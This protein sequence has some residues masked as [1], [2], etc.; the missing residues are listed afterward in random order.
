MTVFS[1]LGIGKAERPY[2][3]LDRVAEGFQPFALA[4]LVEEAVDRSNSILFIARN[5]QKIST[6]KQAL[7]FINPNLSVLHFPAWDC[8]P[9]DR[10]SPGKNVSSR[11]LATLIRLQNL[12]KNPHPTVI[13]T[14]VNAVIQKLLPRKVLEKEI[15]SAQVGQKFDMRCLIN[16][17]EYNGFWRVSIV[18][19]V[20]EYAVRGG[21]VDLFMPGQN[22]PV[23]LDFFNDT[24]EAVRE[25]DPLTQQTR[26][27]Q[28]GFTFQP[29]SEIILAP[30]VIYRFCSNYVQAFGKIQ[31][32]DALYQ[33]V[34]AGR[35]F[36][37]MEHWLPLFYDEVET[38]F[39]HTGSMPVIFD[40]LAEEAL[41]ERYRLIAHYYEI[42]REYKNIRDLKDNAPYHPLPMD[43]FYLSPQAFFS[44]QQQ[45][46]MRIDFTPSAFSD[47]NNSIRVIS[48]N[49]QEFR[50]FSLERDNPNI[51]LLAA[52][53]DY[54][55]TLQSKGRKVLLAGW[56]EGSLNRLIQ[57]FNEQ[58]LKK[59]EQVNTLS[60]VRAAPR[61]LICAGIISIEHGF[62]TN[63]LSVISEKD[64][65]GD[66]FVQ[67][68]RQREHKSDFINET[69][70]LNTGDI[71]VHID[72]GIGRFFCLKTIIASGAPHDCLE[73]HYAEEDR[74]FLPVENIDLLSRYGGGGIDTV[75]D[76]LGSGAW[77]IR[78]AKLKKRLLEMA[79]ELINIAAQRQMLS[80]PKLIPSIDLYDEFSARF[81]YHETEDQK[82]AI[83]AVL[84]DLS[85]GT[86]MDRLI[87]G[88]VGFGKTEVAIRA[89]FSVA[90]SGLQVAVVVPTT[91]LARQHYEIFTA[92][93]QGLPVR[94]SHA[95][96]FVG[97]RE[98]ADI[99]KEIRN[100]TVDIIIGTHTLLSSNVQFANLGL[101]IID[102]EQHFGVKHKERLK[103]LKAEIHVLTLSATPIPRTLQLALTGVRELSL[104]A[105]PPI[106]RIAVK[107]SILPVDPLII[108]E[109][110]LREHCRGG[111]SFYICPR[112]ADIEEVKI[113]LEKHT[114]ELKVTI[115]H[116][117]LAAS[118]L[119]DTMTAFY[120]GQYDILLSTSI[121]ESGLDIPTANTLI[122]HRSD[123]FGLSALYQ[124]RG[125]IGR[126][127]QQAYALFT[128]PPAKILT[129]KAERRFNVL[130]SLN[131]LGAGF[132]LATHDMDIRGAGNLLGEEQ[133]G[134]IKEVG[135]KLYQQ[136]LE[137]AV[138]EMKGTGE[139]NNLHWSPQISIGTS[140]MIP[141][142]YIPD[143]Q[144]RLD[145]YR[146]IGDLGN[147]QA[148]D[149][150][151]IELIDRFG[152]LPMEVEHLLRIV[153]IK[154]LCRK[155]N[156]EKLDAGPKGVVISFRNGTFP[157]SMGLIKLINK[158]GSM[159]KIRADQRVVFTQNWPTT[160][161]R[162]RGIVALLNQLVKLLK[163]TSS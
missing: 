140:I 38:L 114:P 92:R 26:A 107:T 135:F 5:E 65:F 61:D 87:C 163:T 72:H 115:A 106:D 154:V 9:Y 47:A 54:I 33:A 118:Q 108:R 150:F 119:D 58:G 57:L 63:D 44:A 77:Q 141:E 89:A 133:S 131:M 22:I 6:F 78:K 99:K 159:A 16:H 81:P 112:I 71:V 1:K 24:L 144:L 2:L 151:A 28:A 160:E 148:I 125:R 109:A 130:E 127:K 79:D 67:Q 129:L 32:D 137:E 29:M 138:M 55:S 18:R 42:R 100:G 139:I 126:S 102:E 152:P 37:G 64:I 20:G 53:I 158:Q 11:R 113:F 31:R 94:I 95:S 66:R 90:T 104:I 149:T 161:K 143:L 60:A 19:D 136:M 27:M 40:Y 10:I 128:L 162:F 147:L 75:L 3:I 4:K 117:Q 96:R 48:A 41:K 121:V 110:L 70:S 123:M 51:N 52:I 132:Q 80:A 35:R 86:P 142:F 124:L 8:L 34:S 84:N 50:D 145:L 101:L 97:S 82:R 103:K 122:V 134:H 153:Y 30:E 12:R 93:F 156:V 17:L 111:Q 105:T 76:K 39:E 43:K 21:I 36:A 146:R 88:D 23:R 74:L 85:S 7:H 69:N 157:N 45:C 46:G 73:I 13:I 83:D 116:G 120:D 56:S 59:I 62:E 98:L 49:T 91:L 68:A 155:A 14:S 15:I 25:F